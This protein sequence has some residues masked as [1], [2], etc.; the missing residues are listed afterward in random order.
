MLRSMQWVNHRSTQKNFCRNKQ[1]IDYVLLE[2][3]KAVPLFLIQDKLSVT[4][5]LVLLD[6]N[7]GMNYLLI[8]SSQN[9]LTLLKAK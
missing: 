6:E 2:I 4:E 5:V 7:Y 1:I 9:Q 8:L 3:L